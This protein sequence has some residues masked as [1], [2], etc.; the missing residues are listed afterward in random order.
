MPVR[1]TTTNG[2]DYPPHNR[3]IIKRKHPLRKLA[4]YAVFAIF[5]VCFGYAGYIFSG[6][7]DP[8]KLGE[9]RGLESTKIFDRTGTVVLYEFG[10]IRRTYKPFNEISP[11]LKNATVA[12]ED[13]DFYK[14]GGIS[15]RGIFRA[16]WADIRGKSLQG[17][18]T[19]TQQLIKQTMLS[20]ER[21]L[22]RKARE[23]I[24]ALEVDNKLSKDKI[25]ETYLNITPYGSNTS[26]VESAAQAFFGTSAKDL[27]L[28]QASL[29][30]SLPKAP[31]FYSPF[32]SNT[33]KLYARQKLV[34]DQ[35]AVQGYITKDEAEAA[36]QVKLTF[37]SKIDRIQAPHFVFYVREQLEKDFGATLVDA[38][39]LKVITTLDAKMQR[40]A[41]D[42]IALQAPKNLKYGAK[43]AAL[44]AIDP[45]NGDIVAMVGSVDY[46]DTENDGNVNVAIRPR[47]PG[48]SFKPIVYAS[49]LKKG[50]T[51]E[52]MLADVPIDFGT[53]D[54]AYKPFNFDKRFNG[55]VT[56]R[57][58]LARS[59]NIPAVE[60]LYLA[61]LNDTLTLARD[62]GFTS[63]TDPVRYGLSLALGGGEVRLV[64]SVSAFSVFA[65]EGLRRPSR[66]ILKIDDAGGRSL[67]DANKVPAVETRVLEAEIARQVT[68]IMS[69]NNARTPTFGAG[70]P[71]Q[72]G[73]RPVAAKTGTAQDFRDGWTV[74]FTPS[75]VAG[76]W[77]GNN[78]NT[79]ITKQED[80][81]VVAA[82]IWNNFMKTVL[83]NTPIERFTK[84]RAIE[85]ND[86]VLRGKLPTKKYLLD[87]AS[88][89]ILPE[90]CSVPIGKPVEF[91]S[92]HSIL[93]FVDKNNPLSNGPA[94]NPQS[95]PMFSRW[96]AG[97]GSW[98]DKYN[99]DHPDDPKYYVDKLPDASC[100]PSLLENQPK[101][102]FVSPEDNEIFKSPLKLS[103]AIES[104]NAIKKVEFFVNDQKIAEK[105]SEPWEVLYRFPASTTAGQFVLSARATSENNMLGQGK[106]TIQIN[107]GIDIP[108]VSISLPW[109]N[110]TLTATDFPYKVTINA[111]SKTSITG[112][113]LFMSLLNPKKSISIGK[114]N[115]NTGDNVYAVQ[116]NDL[117]APGAY[118]L[119]AVAVSK[120]GTKG[121]SSPITVTIP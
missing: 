77:V 72:M 99:K 52:T 49:L 26:G 91:V 57:Q 33:E 82:P 105:T 25:L 39:G 81:V 30:A 102:S 43:N 29:L 119:W 92:F 10:E 7:P 114:T 19:I 51:T 55:P 93:Y 37:K 63:L 117:P 120:S 42:A 1:R 118:S 24:L 73:A 58:A 31:T 116:W 113:E 6:I 96:E 61:G 18:S 78:D 62:M 22:T 11:F 107:P 66:S 46:F 109:P 111:S 90:D 35:M 108:K 28:P 86:Q 76:V 38:G 94:A 41:E 36:K 98:R 2:V 64:D 68:D 20:P 17:G 40:S 100:D 9:Q 27:S 23:A 5:I 56:V 44:V 75:L 84:P 53:V 88:G 59:L 32:G 104:P 121:Q 15:F 70:S 14:H 12:I 69:D 13:K 47:S 60:A 101:V 50:F 103:V 65:S 97:V 95:D 8:S 89:T 21:T 45:K 106:K 83:A 79:P 4:I 85:T 80:G 16:L 87:R 54:K 3:G 71:L 67:Y 34:L 48:S 115:I 74:G 110:S 112:V